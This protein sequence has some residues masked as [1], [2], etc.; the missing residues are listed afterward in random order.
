MTEQEA[1][2][3]ALEKL[4]FYLSQPV[5]NRMP[6]KLPEHLRE[7]VKLFHNCCPLCELFCF[8]P[9]DDYHCEGCPLIIPICNNYSDA[10]IRKNIILIQAWEV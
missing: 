5:E 9:R 3:I 7:K 6:E 8:S 4:N 2:I 10:S 1:K